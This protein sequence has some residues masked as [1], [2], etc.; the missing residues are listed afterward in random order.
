MC[1]WFCPVLEQRL[2]CIVFCV[3]TLNYESIN[4]ALLFTLCFNYCPYSHLAKKKNLLTRPVLRTF[5]AN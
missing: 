3:C 2:T 4:A 1:C 5:E